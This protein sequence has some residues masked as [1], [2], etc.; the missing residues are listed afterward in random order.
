MSVAVV[1]RRNGGGRKNVVGLGLCFS[2]LVLGV[3]SADAPI[4]GR[5]DFSTLLKGLSGQTR[6]IGSLFKED[7]KNEKKFVK[8]LENPTERE[9]IAF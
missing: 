5:E 9:R 7:Q 3:V 1:G 6:W 4:R 8:K 2:F